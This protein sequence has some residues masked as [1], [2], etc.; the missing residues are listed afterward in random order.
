MPKPFNPREQRLRVTPVNS[1]RI[2]V[3][4]VLELPE[5]QEVVLCGDFNGWSP[6]SLRTIRCNQ[7]GRWEKRLTLPPGR[8]EYKCVV[9]AEWVRDPHARQNVPNT[10]NSLISARVAPT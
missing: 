6:P 9:D 8:Y 1:K 2:E 3:T 10:G 7:N 4:F 5:A